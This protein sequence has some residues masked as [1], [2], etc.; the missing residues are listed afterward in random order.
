[1][2]EAGFRMMGE[3]VGRV[4]DRVLGIHREATIDHGGSW[5]GIPSASLGGLGLAAERPARRYPAW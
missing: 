2:L 5:D 4:L 1:V 3:T